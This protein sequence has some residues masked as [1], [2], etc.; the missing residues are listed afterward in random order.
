MLT[1]TYENYFAESLSIY[2]L[3]IPMIIFA[4][5]VFCLLQKDGHSLL[6]TI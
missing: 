2:A 5:T 6:H 1:Q 3:A 4:I